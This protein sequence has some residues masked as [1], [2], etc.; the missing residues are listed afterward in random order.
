MKIWPFLFTNGTACLI[1]GGSTNNGFTNTFNLKYKTSNINENPIQFASM[2]HARAG[3]ACTIFN[4][5][6]H[7]GRPVAIVAGGYGSPK[8]AEIL[9]FTQQGSSW[10][11]SKLIFLL[12]YNFCCLYLS[13]R[14]ICLQNH[15]APLVL[16]LWGQTGCQKKQKTSRNSN[17]L[18]WCAT[19][20][21]TLKNLQKCPKLNQKHEKNPS[22]FGGFLKFVQF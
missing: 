8:K 15:F 18:V 3:H 11:K 10:Q 5:P 19:F 17:F 1:S 13:H 7:N 2:V 4:S 14:G 22:F 20:Q 12:W 9:D 21:S 16:R 6:A